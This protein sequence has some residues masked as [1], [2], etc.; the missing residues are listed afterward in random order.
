MTAENGLLGI[1]AVQEAGQAVNEWGVRVEEAV[2]DPS[3]HA[4][5]HIRR[6]VRWLKVEPILDFPVVKRQLVSSRKWRV[7]MSMGDCPG[8]GAKKM[9]N[10]STSYR[11]S[12]VKCGTGKSHD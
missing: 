7:I 2:E 11:V 5:D 1:A 8:G 12:H 10:S 6:V 9:I 4:G 3:V